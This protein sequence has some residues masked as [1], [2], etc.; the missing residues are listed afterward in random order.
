MSTKEVAQALAVSDSRVRQRIAAGE[1]P[2]RKLG[3][4]WVML[5]QDV[6]RLAKNPPRRGRPPG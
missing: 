3:S 2:A 4:G 5:K 6:R 1:I